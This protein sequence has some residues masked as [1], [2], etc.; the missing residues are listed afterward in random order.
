MKKKTMKKLALLA[1]SVAYLFYSTKCC[2]KC[3]T[4]SCDEESLDGF[5][6]IPHKDEV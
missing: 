4:D 5:K 6:Q 1:T 2:K 3:C